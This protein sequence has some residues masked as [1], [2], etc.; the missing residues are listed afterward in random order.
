MDTEAEGPLSGFKQTSVDISVPSGSASVPARTFTVS[1]LH[2][3]KLTDILESAFQAPIASQ[4]HLTPFRLFHQHPPKNPGETPFEQRVYTELY[5]SEA[6][7][8]EHDRVQRMP[9]EEALPPDKQDCKLERVVAGIKRRSDATKL[10]QFGT[11]S[12]WPIYLFLANLSK[13]VRAQPDS[14]ACHHVA[15]IPAVDDKLL[16][17]IA[18]WHKNWNASTKKDM[19]THCKRELMHAIWS[20]LLDDDF[21]RAYRYGMVVKCWDGIWRRLYPRLLTYSADYPEKV[22]LANVRD[23]GSCPCPRCLT[24][25]KLVNLMGQERDRAFRTGP[26][27]RKF[28]FS[29]VKIARKFIYESGGG[30][31]SKPVERLLK[32]TSSVPTLNAF[33]ECLGHDFQLHR[34]LVIDLLHEFELGVWKVFFAHLIRLLYAHINGVELVGKLD[35]RLRLI[36][37]FGKDTIRRFANNASEMKKLAARDFEDLLQ[38]LIPAFEGLMEGSDNKLIM[39][40]LFKMAE[41]HAFAKLRM[42]TDETILRLRNLTKDLSRLMRQF[43]RDVCSKYKTKELPKEKAARER[44]KQQKDAA[45]AATPGARQ[46][47]DKAPPAPANPVDADSAQE[48]PSKVLHKLLNLFTY[49]WHALGDYDSTI[50]IFSTTDNYSTQL[51]EHA[52]CHVKRIY[53]VTNKNEAEQQ[54]GKRTLQAQRMLQAE[55]SLAK[56]G[57]HSH[58]PSVNASDRVPQDFG[59]EEHIYISKSKDHWFDMY[60]LV[61]NNREDPAVHDFIP[62]LREHLLARIL[63]REWN[64]E[65]HPDFTDPH[66]NCIRLTNNRVYSVKT[67]R[68]NYTTYDIRRE[69]DTINPSTQCHVI[70]PSPDLDESVTPYWY[71]KVIGVFHASVSC[72][73]P[74]GLELNGRPLPAT[75]A[76]VIKFLWVRW[77]ADEKQERYRWG[78]KQARL[79]KVGFV[80]NSDPY[81]FG[82][83]DPELVIRACHI[84]PAFHSGRTDRLMVSPNGQPIKTSLA[85]EPGEMDDYENY[86]VGIFSDRDMLMRFTGGGIGHL[87]V[88]SGFRAPELQA[89][90]DPAE[91]EETGDVPVPGSRK[92]GVDDEDLDGGLSSDEEDDEDEEGAQDND[93]D[94]TA[95][96]MGLED[97]DDDDDGFAAY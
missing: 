71:A 49:K 55:F 61:S 39:T 37:R 74:P 69:R 41:W 94:N 23:K 17:Q 29:A 67:V 3:R 48:V 56:K 73:P 32:E 82:F 58:L 45:I 86:Y 31:R 46:R 2:L 81:S 9:K 25:M 18:G 44:R 64:G 8:N 50:P 96:E 43:E 19:R 59:E 47:Q 62:K 92:T 27:V 6:M 24:P 5:N 22:L 95:W 97:Q 75:S 42:H 65:D 91:V 60:N 7:I 14:G 36:P 53:R 88:F 85:R 80:P 40:L 28:F 30:L 1:G 89:E 51:G 77:M 16:E 34:M 87:P 93:D 63:K 35:A 68:V 57:K 66:L 26:G 33:L 4:Y 52:H 11:A 70:V 79:P 72:V 38:C 12:L 78:F 54:I 20:I 90:D 76:E 13:Y 10:A 84:I 15:Y 21:R 83:L